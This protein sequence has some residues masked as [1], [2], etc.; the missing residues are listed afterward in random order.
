MPI[1]SL[2]FGFEVQ[3]KNKEILNH[4]LSGCYIYGLYLEGCGW[5]DSKKVLVESKPKEL[6]FELPTIHIIPKPP[7]KLD[8]DEESEVPSDSKDE[9]FLYK[10]PP[11]I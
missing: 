8:E 3:D 9:I 2:I 6:F 4:P 5:D 7:K 11:C 1:D 10:Y